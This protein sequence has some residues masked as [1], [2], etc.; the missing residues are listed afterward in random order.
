M[1]KTFII[2]ALAIP[3]M[4]LAEKAI[5]K[6]ISSKWLAYLLTFLACSAILLS[7]HL[8]AYLIGF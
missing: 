1:L 4:R 3:F 5:D 6:R 2:V 8:I 7:L